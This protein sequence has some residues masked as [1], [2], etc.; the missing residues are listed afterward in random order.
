MEII[1]SY[2]RMWQIW[3]NTVEDY[4]AVVGGE[5]G[6]ARYV[7]VNVWLSAISVLELPSARPCTPLTLRD[8]KAASALYTILLNFLPL[9]IY[10][11]TCRAG[12]GTLII[13]SFARKMHI[14]AGFSASFIECACQIFI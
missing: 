12:I 2:A 1:I 7:R 5:E 6:G 10:A 9:Y 14:A 3:Q 8:N 4:R 13:K 11:A